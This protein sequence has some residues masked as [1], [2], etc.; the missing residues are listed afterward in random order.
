MQDSLLSIIK[1]WNKKDNC[2]NNNIDI[3]NWIDERNR[4]LLVDI[5]ENKLEDS[6]FWFYNEEK[7]IIQ[8][9]NNS[10]FHIIGLREYYKLEEKEEIVEQPIIIQ[11]EIG[12]LGIICKEFNGIMYFL[13][14]AKI[15]P[16]N[17][18]K[19]QLSPTIQATKSNFTQ[20]H[21][22][23]RPAYIDYFINADKY[24]IIVDQI[25]SEQSS[26]FYKKRN[27][28]I[29]IKVNENIKVLPSHKWM[30]LGQIKSLMRIDNL[31]NMDTRT[32]LSC[33]PYYK[34][35]Y[36]KDKSKIKQKFYDKTLYKSIIN[37]DEI[38]LVNIY[39]KIN[40]IKMY[41]EKTSDFVKLKDLQSW[42]VQN[43]EFV[44][45]KPYP[46]RVI[47]CKIAIEG[48]EVAEWTQPLFA[49]NGD[50][51]FGLLMRNNKNSKRE[52]LVKVKHEVGCYDEVE[53]APTLQIESVCNEELDNVEKYFLNQVNNKKNIV[54]DH[55]LSEE[56]GRFYHEQNRN[57]LIMQNDDFDIDLPNEYMW[58]DYKTLNYLVQHNNILNIQLRNLLSLLEI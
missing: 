45:K 37:N 14:Q 17:I 1:S 44:C 28:N 27:R 10:F 57:I 50:A 30:T 23:K 33:I 9:K 2:I 38:N 40:D 3:I 56:G 24:E 25:Q 8:N 46:F 35:N 36:L 32:V 13:M 26:R 51:T 52:F 55:M 39:K 11:D 29:I 19:I 43:G 21:G 31:V 54:F 58:L 5:T 4:N 48:R 22:G 18:N 34:L 7:G 47:F 20:K 6:N 41:S 42:H 49:A 16:G 53:L 12:Y 15:E